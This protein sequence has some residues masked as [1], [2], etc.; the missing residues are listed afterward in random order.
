LDETLSSLQ[1][2]LLIAM[3]V[4][5]LMLAAN[6]QSFRV[7][8]VILTAAPAVVLGSLLLLLATGSTLNLQSYM[9]IILAVGVSLANG[10]LLITNAEEIR[11]TGKSAHVAAR[12]AASLRLRPIIM[13]SIAMMAG[14]LPMAIGHGEAGEQVAPL[15]RAVIGGLLFST[16]AVLIV[17]PLIFAWIQGKT[18]IQSPS[19]DPE[20][21]NSKFYEPTTT[22]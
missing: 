17:L 4:V 9:G 19:L 16:F 8:F 20:D 11:K 1:S 5:F 7:S 6:F 15:G 22:N 2:G 21:S 13:T 12:E 18:T 3:V 10:V 14:M